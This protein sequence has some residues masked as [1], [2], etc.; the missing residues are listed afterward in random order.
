MTRRW[1]VS[2]QHGTTLRIHGDT[3]TM[4]PPIV[5]VEDFGP[6][7]QPTSVVVI[8]EVDDD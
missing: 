5:H 6:Q 3:M 4:R 8:I 1:E 7:P 2:V